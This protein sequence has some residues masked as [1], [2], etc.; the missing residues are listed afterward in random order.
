MVCVS[1]GLVP[2][3]KTRHQLGKIVPQHTRRSNRCHVHDFAVLEQFELWCWAGNSEE[4]NNRL[5]FIFLRLLICSVVTFCGENNLRAWGALLH[6]FFAFLFVQGQNDVEI[7]GVSI[8]IAV[9]DE[10]IAR[11]VHESESQ[12]HKKVNCS[13]LD[14]T[15]V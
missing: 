11:N 13:T 12:F 4:A 10:S 6:V 2:V 5:F 9:R 1:I 8:P 3:R 7:V 15:L 14:Q